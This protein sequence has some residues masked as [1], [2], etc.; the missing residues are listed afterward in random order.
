MPTNFIHR[1]NNYF[2]RPLYPVVAFDYVVPTAIQSGGH[3]GSDYLPKPRPK[4]IWS[5]HY[6]NFV[7]NPITGKVEFRKPYNGG[8]IEDI[9]TNGKPTG[10]RPKPTTEAPAVDNED[11]TE[12][13]PSEEPKEEAVTEAPEK[14]N[15]EE[16]SK[17]EEDED[18]KEDGGEEDEE[19]VK[20]EDDA[21]EE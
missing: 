8:F 12:P 6:N 13:K 3:Y 14:P 11:K 15:G 1:P 16:D 7:F 9:S 4:S 20:E 10:N 21:E 2:H 18:K 5:P 17:K 19:S